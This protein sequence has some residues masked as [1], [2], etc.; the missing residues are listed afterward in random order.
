MPTCPGPFTTHLGALENLTSRLG[1]GVRS[2]GVAGTEAVISRGCSMCWDRN[3][4]T[5]C[6]L[7]ASVLL[8][9]LSLTLAALPAIHPSAAACP[10]CSPPKPQPLQFKPNPVFPSP[11]GDVTHSIPSPQVWGPG[12]PLAKNP[13]TTQ[14]LLTGELGRRWPLRFGWGN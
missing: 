7:H 9:E 12:D 1:L 13:I 10:P 3:R 6:C 14:G 2:P 11:H 5:S 4:H 8:P